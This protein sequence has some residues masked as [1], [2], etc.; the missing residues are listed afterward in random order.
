[1]STLRVSDKNM[2]SKI[3]L[4]PF[5][6]EEDVSSDSVNGICFSHAEASSSRAD[7]DAA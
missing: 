4:V 2:Q 5:E 6:D 3:N 1:M 7:S